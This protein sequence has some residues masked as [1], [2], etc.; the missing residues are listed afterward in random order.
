M[1]FIVSD[2][3]KNLKRKLKWLIRRSR[4]GNFVEI[5]TQINQVTRIWIN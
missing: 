2:P 3:L 5:R 1:V 4:T